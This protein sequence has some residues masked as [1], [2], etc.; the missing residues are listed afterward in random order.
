MATTVI[1]PWQPGGVPARACGDRRCTQRCLCRDPG[2]RRGAFAATRVYAEVPLPRPGCTQRC[3][4]G[5]PAVRKGNSAYNG[6]VA[7][8]VS[9]YTYCAR[10]DPAV[11][12]WGR[13]H[14]R[15][16]TYVTGG[17]GN[18]DARRNRSRGA[19]RSGATVALPA[20][21]R[22]QVNLPR[23]V[24]MHRRSRTDGAVGVAPRLIMPATSGSSD[25]S[26]VSV[27]SK[28]R[29]A[30]QHRDVPGHGCPA[31]PAVARRVPGDPEHRPAGHKSK[32]WP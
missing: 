9:G 25:V 30:R 2:V 18:G 5:D 1:P 7:V 10:H 20:R 26:S 27:N 4:C 14:L 3:L 31:G 16:D 15:R 13:Q 17:A 8:R 19:L 12:R 11:A 22:R 24:A 23:L 28:P 6:A 32:E 21:A 29:A